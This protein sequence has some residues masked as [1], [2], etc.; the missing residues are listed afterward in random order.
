MVARDGHVNDP[1]A[2]ARPRACALAGAI[3][4]S[5]DA[6]YKVC[7][8]SGIVNSFGNSVVVHTDIHN[9]RS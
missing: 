2:T 1:T 9:I 8:S 4:S 6:V 3:P 7:S 5:D